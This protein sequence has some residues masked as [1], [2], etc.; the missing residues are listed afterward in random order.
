MNSFHKTVD[1][2]CA[3]TVCASADGNMCRANVI[4][5]QLGAPPGCVLLFL[6][7]SCVHSVHCSTFVPWFIF[8]RLPF[9]KL[10]NATGYLSKWFNT[11]SRCYENWNPVHTD[12]F[13]EFLCC[14]LYI[15]SELPQFWEL[16][17]NSFWGY[18]DTHA[19]SLREV[20]NI[21]AGNVKFCPF[22][23]SDVACFLLFRGSGKKLFLDIST[24]A[25][26][27]YITARQFLDALGR[28]PG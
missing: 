15:M 19:R 24:N 22:C 28:L 4:R 21:W 26:V 2:C 14:P 13:R 25:D 10:V 5:T 12:S 1:L 6:I 16:V 17:R 23:P 27:L 7:P 8:W 3:A 11:L 18:F 20:C 9:S